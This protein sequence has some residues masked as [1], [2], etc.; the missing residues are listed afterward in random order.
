IRDNALRLLNLINDLLDLT[1]LEVVGMKVEA[2][3]LKV[4]MPLAQIGEEASQLAARQG[5]A[6]TV[7]LDRCRSRWKLDP[8]HLDKIV[9]NLLSNALKFTPR[10]G[11][12]ELSAGEDATG[13]VIR[14]KDDGPGIPPEAMARL[15]ERFFRVE[16]AGTRGRGGTG[17]GLAL[18]RELARLMGGDISVASIGRGS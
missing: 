9:L 7:D 15:F 5:I 1:R 16:G 10:G 18:A 12:V 6:F 14:V 17:I 13:L 8:R 2:V 3:P 4:S 11:R